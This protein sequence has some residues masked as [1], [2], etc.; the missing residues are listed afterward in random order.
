VSERVR[1]LFLE[2]NAADFELVSDFLVSESLNC[3]IARAKNRADFEQLFGASSFDLILSDY[4]IPG[5]SGFAALTH[6]RAKDPAIPFILLSGTLSEE[7]AV[8][9]LR[10]GAT[11]YIIKQR[12]SRLAPAIRRALKEADIQRKTLR[13]AEAL[14][15]SEERFKLAARAT[16]DVIW[17]WDVSADEIWCNE[18]FDVLFGYHHGSRTFSAQEKI[19]RIHRSDQTR[20]ARHMREKL[21][22]ADTLW[23]EEYEFQR[24]DGR[25][26][27]VLDRGLI[28]RDEHGR[29][30][31]VIGA[32]TDLTPRR[33]AEAQIR[34]QAALLDKARDAII[35]VGMDQR[36]QYWNHSAERIFGWSVAEVIGRNISE[37]LL[38]RDI[39]KDAP[40]LQRLMSENEWRG[41]LEVR[42]KTGQRIVVESRWSLMRDAEER[43]PKGILLI[44]TDVTEKKEIEA[45][46][47]R[48]QRIQTIGELSGGIA[49]D[50]NNALAPIVMAGELLSDEIRSESGTRM[51]E[52]IRTSAKRCGDMVK[53]ILSFSR[54][55][56]QHWELL[57]SCK[58]I[59]EIAAL[60]RETFPKLITIRTRCEPRANHFQ[61]NVTQIHQVIMNLLVNARDA[62]PEGGAIT[63]TVKNVLL[64][65]YQTKM[66]TAPVSGP[67]VSVVVSD[68]GA[69]IPPEIVDR[70]FEPFFTTKELGKGTGLG[71][72]TVFSIVKNHGGFLEL[73][74]ESG[75]GAT[76]ELFFPAHVRPEIAPAKEA[77]AGLA[78]ARGEQLLIVDD[79]VGLLAMVKSTL[80]TLGYRVLTAS[81]GLEALS[82]LEHAASGVDLVLTDWQMPLMSGR[83]LV[84]KIN[85]AHPD[86]KILVATGS[87]LADE[88]EFSGLPICGVLQK[89]YSTEGML[90]SIR[91]ALAAKASGGE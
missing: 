50:L 16:N 47:L 57:D 84:Q 46:F 67:F 13:A 71:L 90:K 15:A 81:D 1:I 82:I 68:T 72:S 62:M 79:E 12:L 28:V 20:V 54:G 65:D 35:L 78:P 64:H 22:S 86:L 25:Y 83:D 60:T 24:R 10:A 26:A 39:V 80:E 17:E 49:H 56:G 18:T 8:A 74:T 29:A 91:D 89:P 41:E 40:L 33:E 55:T 76:F 44:N 4:A 2:D 66:L 70:V 53:Q 52:M 14:R 88:A 36:I 34:E 38:R 77:T 6:V 69:G 37:F 21:Q 59:E 3:D 58:I 48:A 11:D 73:R 31:R 51:I 75:K 87:A 43:D 19:A 61:G 85:A 23:V 32:M 30:L 45:Q 7:E 5:Y 42:A 9:S 27:H 63:L